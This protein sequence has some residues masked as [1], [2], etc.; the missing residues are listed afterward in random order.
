MQARGSLVVGLLALALAACQTPSTPET[1]NSRASGTPSTRPSTAPELIGK[2]LTSFGGYPPLHGTLV[3]HTSDGD[4]TLR[5]WVLES[6]FR[7]ELSAA[8]GEPIPWVSDGVTSNIS[9]PHLHAGAFLATDPREILRDCAEPALAGANE[10]AGRPVTGI[11]CD[12]GTGTEAGTY[13]VDDATGIV[14]RGE[15]TEPGEASWEFT[16]IDFNPEFPPGVF[17]VPD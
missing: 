4:L 17:V 10:V 9:E 7:V 15:P 12:P 11:S 6:K 16:Q 13:W 14:M 8:G 2:V 1:S 3:F 5:M